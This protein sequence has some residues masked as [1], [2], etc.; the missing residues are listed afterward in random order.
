MASTARSLPTATA[1]L[2]INSAVFVERLGVFLYAQ[3]DLIVTCLFE[4]LRTDPRTRLRVISAK[5]PP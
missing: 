3:L 2:V 5:K 4:Q 1:L